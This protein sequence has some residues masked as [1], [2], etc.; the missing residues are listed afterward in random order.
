MGHSPKRALPPNAFIGAKECVQRPASA[1]S[2]CGLVQISPRPKVPPS[3]RAQLP[4]V[5]Y[6]EANLVFGLFE[7]PAHP[8]SGQMRNRI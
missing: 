3:R 8:G 5:H 1:G 7:M 6:R 4:L 2:R